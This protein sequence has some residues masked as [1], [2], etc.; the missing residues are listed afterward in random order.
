MK[1]TIN[2]GIKRLTVLSLVIALMLQ[3][4]IP[5]ASA[6]PTISLSASSIST[7]SSAGSNT[8]GVTASTDTWTVSTASSGWLSASKVSSTAVRVAWTENTDSASRSG[9]VTVTNLTASA[10]LT[11]TQSAGANIITVNPSSLSFAASGGSEHVSV[12]SSFNRVCSVA[13]KPTWISVSSMTLDSAEDLWVTADDNST[14]AARS[15]S[16]T[17]TSP[18]AAS[19]SI[20][21]TQAAGS[22]VITVTPNSLYFGA[23][24]G[25]KSVNATSSFNLPCTVTEKPSWLTASGVAADS[26]EDLAFTASENN[27]GAARSGLITFSSGSATKSINVSQGAH[28]LS[29]S[30]STYAAGAASGSF[31]ITAV[32]DGGR[33]SVSSDAEWLRGSFDSAPQSVGA[34]QP[35]GETSYTAY[36]SFDANSGANPRTAAISFSF[37]GVTRTL[38]VT[39]EGNVLTFEPDSLN[40]S[41]AGGTK[42]IDVYSVVSGVPCEL[43]QWPEW[44]DRPSVS[45]RTFTVVAQPNETGAA[46]SGEL[47][48]ISEDITAAIPVTQDAAEMTVSTTYESVAAAAS[49]FDVT[50]QSNSGRPKVYYDSAWIHVALVENPQNGAEAQAAD[51]E[52]YTI[53]VSLDANA[54]GSARRG[55]VKF[56]SAG[57]E[58]ILTIDQ[59]ANV[60]TVDPAELSFAPGGETKTVTASASSGLE[61][62]VTEK[63]DWISVSGEGE[64]SFTAEA[65]SSGADRSGEIVLA[66]GEITQTIPVTQ[67]AAEMTVSTTYESVAAAAS[68]FDVTVQ[69]NSGRPKVYYDSAWI[70]V[71]LVENPQ[72]GAEAQAADMETYT[73]RV[74]LDAN[75]TGSARR[76]GVKFASAGLETI[77]T[78]DQA[79]NVLTVDPAELSFAPGGET[80]TVTASASSGLEITVT[81]KPDWIS[82]SGEGELSFTAEANSSGAA[83]SGTVVLQSGSVQV[84][85]PV[86]QAQQAAPVLDE[87]ITIYNYISIGTEIQL[88]FSVR[89]TV[90]DRFDSWYVEVKKL[91]AEGNTLAAKRFGPGQEGEVTDGYV[92]RAL[93]T[94]ITAKEMSTRYEA[95]F[96]GFAADGSETY[97][98]PVT[99]TVR[100]YVV[101]ELTRDDN[102]DAVRKLAA[103]LLNFGAAAQVYFNYDTDNLVNENLSAAAQAA[104][105]HFATT[106]EAPAVLVNSGRG[107]TVYSSVSVM[108]RVILSLTVRGMG[109]AG[110]V[111]IL[112]RNHDSGAE[113]DTLDTV[114]LGTV[115]MADYAGFEPKDMRT[116]YD[117]IALADGVETGTPLTW[118]VE[119]YAREARL[120]EETTQAE[121]NL[122]NALLHY[123]DAAAAV[124][125]L[126]P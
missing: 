86:S 125:A 11:V 93:Y 60:L 118:S 124:A 55:G 16:I 44:I 106:G 109:N 10:S 25:T 48:F 50:V 83:R 57:L 90:T 40:F 7:G 12:S 26:A 70:H 81:E 59:A 27:T 64:L 126:E 101:N 112:I 30:E 45:G 34:A 76:G 9:T 23:G 20:S 107:P 67:D 89:K 91:D 96:H 6:A 85:I 110:N 13:S 122:F 49:F 92:R 21:V 43:A 75:A 15:G 46:R 19:K 35:T 38:T 5:T 98:S 97:S 41:P 71:A 80:K 1:K 17:I 79:A 74:S 108:N 120:N 14:G 31:T 4:F 105:E 111:K 77:L 65:N 100:D 29:I 121:L 3:F 119:G 52:T 37:G 36:I 54:T 123:V 39:Q 113:V 63:P 8:L 62:T 56:A 103:D 117:F 88:A 69:S 102:L 61:I 28:T 24:G 78:I 51:M 42:T 104:M 116:A 22:N 18:G 33:P 66:C 87:S 68:F 95:V 53:R 82:V 115:W 84:S 32:T 47:I 94:D 58:T 73:I 72:N 114:K 99:N 2:M